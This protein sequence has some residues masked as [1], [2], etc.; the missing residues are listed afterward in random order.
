MITKYK[1]LRISNSK[2]LLIAMTKLGLK[3]VDAYNITAGTVTYLS[4]LNKMLCY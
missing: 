2:D 3:Y 1:K 4:F